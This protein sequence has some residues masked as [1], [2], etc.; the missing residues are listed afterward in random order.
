M[1]IR[2]PHKYYNIV[3]F[4][5]LNSLWKLSSSYGTSLNCLISFEAGGKL[6]TFKLYATEEQVSI[7]VKN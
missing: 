4:Y 6:I 2:V 7:L 1:Y 3:I 5:I